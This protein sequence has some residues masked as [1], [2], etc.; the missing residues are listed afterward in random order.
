MRTGQRVK[1]RYENKIYI[2]EIIDIKTLSNCTL[3][4]IDVLQNV[5]L[6]IGDIVIY[7]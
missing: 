1:I 6:D 4:R 2:G 5:W 3:F 7:C